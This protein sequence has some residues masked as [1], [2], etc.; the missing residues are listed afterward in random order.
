VWAR[1]LVLI[2]SLLIAALINY[3][4]W[5]LDALPE[6]VTRYGLRRNI[7]PP[8]RHGVFLK[9]CLAHYFHIVDSLSSGCM[10]T[11]MGY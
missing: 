4:L 7:G 2:K 1:D 11:D 3:G 8:S 6:Y 10:K 9:A 5:R